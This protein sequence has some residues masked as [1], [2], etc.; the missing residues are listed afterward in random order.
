MLTLLAGIAAAL[1]AAPLNYLLVKLLGRAAIPALGPALEETLKTGLALAIGASLVGVHSIFGLAEAAWELVFAAG[2][3]KPALAA[4]AAH[5]FFGV[6]VSL[7]YARFGHTGLA[8]ASGFLA[9]L[10]W[11]QIILSLH[12]FSNNKT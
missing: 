8:W 12:H 7:T 3:V 1:G 2:K 11:N 9:H 5:T 6:L 4:V 10:T